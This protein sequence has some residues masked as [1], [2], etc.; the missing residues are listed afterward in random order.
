MLPQS[1]PE[2]RNPPSDST[3]PERRNPPS[4]STKLPISLGTAEHNT[5]HSTSKN[6]A[7][8]C[9][10]DL[11]CNDD[12]YPKIVGVVNDLCQQHDTVV[13]CINGDFVTKIVPG[14]KSEWVVIGNG[15]DASGNHKERLIKFQGFCSN[16]RANSKVQLVINLGN[17][18]FMHPKEVTATLKAL[19]ALGRVHVVS[20]ID[21]G[22]GPFSGLVK[23]SVA[24]AG[25]TFVGYCTNEIF[26]DLHCK[27][28]KDNGYFVGDWQNHNERFKTAIRKVDTPVLFLLSHETRDKSGKY[29]WPM[30]SGCC[31][32][33][34]K[35]KFIAIGHDHFDF[36]KTTSSRLFC[37]RQAGSVPNLVGGNFAGA[38]RVFCIPPYGFGVGIL[39]FSNFPG[40]GIS[41]TKSLSNRFD[42]ASFSFK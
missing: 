10:T 39:K 27:Y 1:K 8:A 12:Q 13:M 41:S 25:I 22:N 23:P 30:L 6:V 7:I 17:H 32:S 20:N 35:S 34:V 26:G 28:A 3:K 29:V 33:S 36:R 14:L 15:A 24:I 2:H 18:E 21:P 5:V 42:S 38:D 16:L 31:P 40:H 4:D 19:V 37:D 9:V 11:H